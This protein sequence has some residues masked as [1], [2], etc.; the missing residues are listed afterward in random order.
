VE[1]MKSKI[2]AGCAALM[3]LVVGVIGAVVTTASP[4]Q[5]GW[6]GGNVI[7]AADDSGYND[8]IAI[9]CNWNNPWGYAKYLA[10][11]WG[12]KSYCSDADGVYVGAGRQIS[13]RYLGTYGA[14]NKTF[15][16]TGWHK[17]TDVESWVCYHQLD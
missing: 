2:A 15:D 7:H 17:V 11:G 1:N 14:Y 16:A 9:T 6:P 4:A 5:A 13:C 3:L 8:P 12:S 10:V